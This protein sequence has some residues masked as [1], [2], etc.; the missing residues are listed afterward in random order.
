MAVPMD[1]WAHKHDLLGLAS[2]LS[3]YDIRAGTICNHSYCQARNRHCDY[4]ITTTHPHSKVKQNSNY[5]YE[6]LLT[7]TTCP[8]QWT[9]WPL[10][11]VFIAWAAEFVFPC[12]V[13][14]PPPGWKAKHPYHYYRPYTYRELY[15]NF[16]VLH[17]T[18]HLLISIGRSTKETKHQ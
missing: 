8:G 7:S 9:F 2:C 14:P 17:F 15:S 1:L 4:F 5:K 11:T 3:E 10:A 13:F 16:I 12:V 6:V 18:T